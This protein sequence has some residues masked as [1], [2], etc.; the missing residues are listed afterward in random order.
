MLANIFEHVQNEP[1]LLANIFMHQQHDVEMRK[2][3]NI[4]GQHCWQGL[5]LLLS[6][7]YRSSRDLDYLFSFLLYTFFDLMD[8]ISQR[9]CSRSLLLRCENGIHTNI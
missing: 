2:Q 3:Q 5:L 4:V 9:G 7:R 6:S 1:T 8:E